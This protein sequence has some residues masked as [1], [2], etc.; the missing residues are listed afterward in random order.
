VLEAD[1]I[2]KTWRAAAGSWSFPMLQKSYLELLYRR[3]G[4]S[5]SKIDVKCLIIQYI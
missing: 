3:D 2:T 4:E 1:M 5:S